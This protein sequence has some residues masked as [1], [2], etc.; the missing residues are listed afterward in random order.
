MRSAGAAASVPRGPV[1]RPGAV[2]QSVRAEDPAD[3]FLNR[4]RNGT[5][6]DPARAEVTFKAVA[7]EWLTAQHFDRKHTANGYRRII[8]GTNDLMETFGDEPIGAINYTAVLRYIKDA[9]S[10]LAAQTV[11]HRF[12]V[13][14]TVLDYAVHNRLLA[15]NVA[16]NVPPRTLPSVKRM[17]AHEEQRYPA[18]AR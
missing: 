11:R 5:Y 17:K 18:H 6:T 7:K 3:D 4:A 9:S 14:R 13:L 12:Y 16:R 15:S 8:E 1:C 2:A 10:R